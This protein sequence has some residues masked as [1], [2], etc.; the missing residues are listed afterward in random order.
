MSDKPPAAEAYEKT[1]ETISKKQTL[2]TICILILLL[3][4]QQAYAGKIAEYFSEGVFGVKWGSTLEE[5]KIVFPNGEVSTNPAT[6]KIN[7]A[8]P[9]G[10]SLFGIKRNPDSWVC[11]NFDDKG[12]FNA[13]VIGFPNTGGGEEEELLNT[14]INDF[15]EYKTV[16]ERGIPPVFGGSFFVWQRDEGIELTLGISYI[17]KCEGPH[18]LDIFINY[19]PQAN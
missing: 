11:Y 10:L 14:V 1:L 4:T 19:D 2:K 6:K 17:F 8:A 16:E 15:G 3:A 7:Y 9:N 18:N 5:V 13:I 12:R